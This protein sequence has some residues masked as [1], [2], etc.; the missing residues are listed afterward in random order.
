MKPSLFTIARPFA[1]A[2]SL[3][4]LLACPALADPPRFSIKDITPPGP[5]D[6]NA[7]AFA[8]NNAGQVAGFFADDSSFFYDDRD[9]SVVNI[10][11]N[12]FIATDINEA[13]AVVGT[14]A[15]PTVILFENGVVTPIAVF[16]GTPSESFAGGLNDAGK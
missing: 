4:L 13:G 14:D 5:A 11:A 6:T 8:I 2:A 7:G 1:T 15:D 12:D 9:G 3:T 16:E 10:P